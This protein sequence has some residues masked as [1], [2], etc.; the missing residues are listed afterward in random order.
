MSEVN[1]TAV[2][3]AR[4]DGDWDLYLVVTSLSLEYDPYYLVGFES[5]PELFTLQYSE[6]LDFPDVW[7]GASNETIG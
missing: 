3:T 4:D 2:Y 1:Y 5:E 6:T 7:E